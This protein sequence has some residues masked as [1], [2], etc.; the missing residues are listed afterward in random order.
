MRELIN[1]MLSSKD[2]VSSNRLVAVVIVVF[3]LLFFTIVFIMHF[4]HDVDT[5]L[6]RYI[7]NSLLTLC[8]GLFGFKMIEKIKTKDEDEV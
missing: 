4:F 6:V 8:G 3:I 5:E 2:D 1:K 7:G